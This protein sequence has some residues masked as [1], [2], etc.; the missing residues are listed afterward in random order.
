MSVFD[1]EDAAR[2]LT[3]IG[4]E[5]G[6]DAELLSAESLERTFERLRSAMLPAET[7]NFPPSPMAVVFL[8]SCSRFADRPAYRI[9][10]EW[11]SWAECALRVARLA[12]QL[13][14]AFPQQTTR[15]GTPVVATLLH[16]SPLLMELFYAAALGNFALLPVNHRLTPN[17][18]DDV[19]ASGAAKVLVT[20]TDLLSKC[21]L[22]AWCRSNRGGTLCQSTTAL[23]SVLDVRWLE[24]LPSGVASVVA[25]AARG[26][27]SI[28]EVFATSGSTGKVKVVP[29][30][31]IAVLTHAAATMAALGISACDDHCW[32]HSGPMF[33]V[34]DVAF[35][36][37][38][39][40]IGAKHVFISKQLQLGLTVTTMA[41]EGVTITKLTPSMLTLMTE[42]NALEGMTFPALQWVLT[43]GAKLDPGLAA[44]A[45]TAL[46][47][48]VLQG[49]GMTEV[50]CHI[51]FKNHTREG[52][53]LGLKTLPG[54]E[55]R[56]FT[57]T[58]ESPRTGEVGEQ[59]C[60]GFEQIQ[61]APRDF[62]WAAV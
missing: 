13:L 40:L 50:T 27:P 29:H 18:L 30:T 14:R 19:L 43:G 26:G 3:A 34:G 38:C 36:W 57:E 62:C 35:V 8:A 45:A 54:L 6:F 11:I 37:I 55:V 47:C 51:A 5:L 33:H 10:G 21:E 22:L 9:D 49:Y 28:V 31:D 61:G 23:N 46:E 20:S 52:S 41:S 7:N 16:N 53:E 12:S 59:G 60:S 25:S 24:R 58:G 17:E 1:L 32:A 15:H 42:S 48:D 39:L 44:R 2:P 56:V 4:R